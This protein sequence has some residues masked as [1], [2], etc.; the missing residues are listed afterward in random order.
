MNDTLKENL[1]TLLVISFI[2]L[3]IVISPSFGMTV[4]TLKAPVKALKADIFG[5]W[6]VPVQIG[7]IVAAIIFSFAKQSLLPFG[8]GAGT[9]AGINFF[10]SYLGTAASGALI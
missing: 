5:G 1:P 10:D 7:G 6:M 3:I 9:V 2:A 4:E 8:I